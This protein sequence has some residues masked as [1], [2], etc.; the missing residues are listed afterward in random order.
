MRLSRCGR[1]D[2]AKSSTVMPTPEYVDD[3]DDDDDDDYDDDDNDATSMG[4]EPR[5]VVVIIAR[6]HYRGPS[7]RIHIPSAAVVT[8][9]TIP[10]PSVVVFTD[11]R[12]IT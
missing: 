9:A 2:S 11:T 6:H 1:V 8:R 7:K 3:D 4:I 12:V 10:T 5:L